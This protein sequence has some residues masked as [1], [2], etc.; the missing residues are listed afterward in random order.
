M[1]VIGA[2]LNFF[3]L[4]V[5]YSLSGYMRIV[6]EMPDAYSQVSKEDGS[7]PS[8]LKLKRTPDAEVKSDDKSEQHIRP[9]FL[10]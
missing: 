5:L 6:V 8:R 10:D 4:S 7:I 2:C 9:P 1:L 3:P